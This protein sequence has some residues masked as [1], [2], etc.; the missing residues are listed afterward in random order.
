[1]R[2]RASVPEDSR[3]HRPEVAALLRKP[4]DEMTWMLKRTLLKVLPT[5]GKNHT[6]E[7]QKLPRGLKVTQQ[8]VSVG[9]EG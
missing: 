3:G 8:E 5:C 4:F 1:M 2:S 6:R 9:S 7:R